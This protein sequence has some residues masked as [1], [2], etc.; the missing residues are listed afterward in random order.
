MS[1]IAQSYGYQN[2]QKFYATYH[3]SYSAYADYREQAADWEKAYGKGRH[4]QDKES[5][6]ERLK[7]HQRKQQ[8]ISNKRQLKA[9]SEG[10]D[11]LS[12]FAIPNHFLMINAKECVIIDLWH[13]VKN[14]LFF[15]GRY[16]GKSQNITF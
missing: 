2:V 8:T 12:V 10:Q 11:R 5:V 7:I 3:K 15:G 6:L 13:I 16:N 4:R 1:G 14:N 9:K